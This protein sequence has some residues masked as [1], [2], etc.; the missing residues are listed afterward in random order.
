MKTTIDPY[1][2]SEFRQRMSDF[3]PTDHED[4][5]A[6]S[7]KLKVE[8]GCFCKSCCPEGHREM[9]KYLHWPPE[10]LKGVKVVEHES[11][12]EILTYMSL[13]GGVFSFAA[14]VI[15]LI[16]AIIQARNEGVRRG[17]KRGHPFKL[18]VRR[19]DDK[20][21]F[22]EDILLEI[23]PDA[24]VDAEK[25]S[26]CL[27]SYAKATAKSSQPKSKKRSKKD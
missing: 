18:I 22:K 8:S 1:W 25:I 10:A 23:P 20:D 6:V 7:I 26:A 27:L 19:L 21:G 15:S 24:D 11:G 9:S 2:L 16:V 3:S 5:L 4:A 12:P 17:D 14:A 13:A